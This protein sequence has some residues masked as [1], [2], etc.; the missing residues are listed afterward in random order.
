MRKSDSNPLKKRPKAKAK[1]VKPPKKKKATTKKKKETA[2]AFVST[3]FAEMRLRPKCE[4]ALLKRL[5]KSA[6]L[7]ARVGAARVQEIANDLA[8]RLEAEVYRLFP[9]RNYGLGVA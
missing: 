8:Q 2:T 5:L 9:F 7:V 6:A 4:K 1:V 3:M